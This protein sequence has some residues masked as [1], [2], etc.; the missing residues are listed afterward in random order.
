MGQLEFERID[1]FQN[2]EQ[3]KRLEKKLVRAVDQKMDEWQQTVSGCTYQDV[4]ARAVVILA[5]V[6][7]PTAVLVG[8]TG[9]TEHV[10]RDAQVHIRIRFLSEQDGAGMRGCGTNSTQQ[11]QPI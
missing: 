9:G 11:C 1:R 10:S 7:Q 8:G 5:Y 3:S 4:K 2:H 6:S